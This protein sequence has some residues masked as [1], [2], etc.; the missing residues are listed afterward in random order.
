MSKRE[1]EDD[2]DAD[3]DDEH[4][5][6]VQKVTTSEDFWKVQLEAIYRRRNPAKL[7]G[8][9]ALLAKYAGKE[10]TLYAKVCKTYDLDPKKFYADPKAWE[11]YEKDT[12]EE[13]A[14][15]TVSPFANG[16]GGVA[17]ADMFKNLGP[18]FGAN[19][20]APASPDSD[21]EEEKAEATKTSTSAAAA[22]KPADCKTS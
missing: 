12:V 11:E 17:I 18:L 20:A 16:T 5:A 14:P 7:E 21:D 10:A 13:M 9:P 1:A 19:K 22:E 3:G 6:K 15:P 2:G 4:K 8:V